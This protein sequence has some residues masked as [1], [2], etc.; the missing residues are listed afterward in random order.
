MNGW[1]ERIK[2]VWVIAQSP[3]G[4]AV[5]MLTVF[6]LWESG[7]LPSWRSDVLSA[8]ARH[9]ANVQSVAV[10]QQAIVEQMIRY[11]EAEERQNRI[12]SII[13]LSLAQNR[14]ERLGCV[15]NLNPRHGNADE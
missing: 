9:D 5:V 10:K 1:A 15:D 11:T 8:I 12:L 2:A 7:I 4:I 3:G 6:V 13:C 14:D